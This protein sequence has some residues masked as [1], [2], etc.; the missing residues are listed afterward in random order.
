MSALPIKGVNIHKCK[1]CYSSNLNRSWKLLLTYFVILLFLR[2]CFQALPRKAEHN[3]WLVTPNP[4]MF[5]TQ[6]RGYIKIKINNN[7]HIHQWFSDENIDVSQL[8]D[9]FWNNS[10]NNL[11]RMI[12]LCPTSYR[13]TWFS[14]MNTTHAT[15]FWYNSKIK[16]SRQIINRKS[17]LPLRKYRRTYPMDSK[18]SLRL[19]S[20]NKK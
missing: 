1:T 8:Y 7:W 6:A 9:L 14:V 2:G 4:L 13:K 18:S 15:L 19:C 5:H 17:Y 11:Q 12:T 16:H 20:G 10:I 3:I